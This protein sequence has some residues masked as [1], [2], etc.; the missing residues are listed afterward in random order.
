MSEIPVIVYGQ[1]DDFSDL[2]KHLK[3]TAGSPVQVF[4]VDSLKS[5]NE[6]IKESKNEYF[7]LVNPN[8][9]IRS[10]G[11]LFRFNDLLSKNNK[12]GIVGGK[13]FDAR[14]LLVS[15]G[16]RIVSYLGIRDVHANIG[17][18]ESDCASYQGVEQADSLLHSLCMIKKRAFDEVGGFDENLQLSASQ[19]FW[20]DDFCMSIRAQGFNVQV[21]DE[22]KLTLSHYDTYLM[23]NDGSLEQPVDDRT[24]NLWRKKWRWH[25]DF[26]DL[27]AIRDR[28]GKTEICWNI[29]N[30]LLDE[31]DSSVPEVDILM[32]TRNN[33]ALLKRT[34]KCLAQTDYENLNLYIL[35]NGPDNESRQI[36]AS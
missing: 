30:N 34:L 8:L 23:L 36:E 14:G 4:Q 24:V 6:R 28:W 11:W 9:V 3:L 12:S 15:F 10:E 33:H 31:W 13:V 35:L 2:E 16:R 25:P 19:P 7:V 22:I 27:H 21:D 32:V 26:P 1:G 5:M 18:G 29:G 17:I 20:L